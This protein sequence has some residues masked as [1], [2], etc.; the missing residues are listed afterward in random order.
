MTKLSIYAY[1]FNA[2]VRDFDL[3][4]TVANFTAFADEVVIA[5][6]KSEDDTYERLQAYETSLG[7]ARFRVV[8]TDIDPFKNNRFDGDLKTAAMKVCSKDNLLIIADCDERFV[9]SQRPLWD[10]WGERLLNTQGVDGL[11]IPVLDLY[12]SRDTIRADQAIGSKFR[13]HKHTVVKRGVP[14]YAERA[15]GLIN[16]AASDT[17]EPLNRM[18][19]LAIF[20]TVVNN[21]VNLRPQMVQGLLGTPFVVHEGWLNLERRVK[22]G[23][24]W[25]KPRWEERSGRKEDVPVD[26]RTLESYPTIKHHLNL[27]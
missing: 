3:D 9:L 18:G 10:S 23:R 25:W 14:S 1:L 7:A 4:G 19:Q 13:L 2:T 27:S 24:E 22:I 5:T 20:A 6:V 15:G 8:M 21:P 17:T 16:T 11:M 26:Q 12:G